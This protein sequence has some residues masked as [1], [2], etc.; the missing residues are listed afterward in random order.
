LITH[1]GCAASKR[2]SC[3]DTRCIT[4]SDQLLGNRFT[5]APKKDM[6]TYI[7]RKPDRL[8]LGLDGDLRGNRH[9]LTGMLAKVVAKP[10]EFM[11]NSGGVH[12]WTYPGLPQHAVYQQIWP[13]F[14]MPRLIYPKKV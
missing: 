7:R 14:P 10:Y 6:K 3:A 1:P 8:D 2:K 4:K 5:T 11:V 13:G 9:G 12:P